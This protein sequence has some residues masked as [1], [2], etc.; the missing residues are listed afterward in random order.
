MYIYNTTTPWRASFWNEMWLELYYV[1]RIQQ[2]LILSCNEGI[3]Y[4]HQTKTRKTIHILR[5]IRYRVPFS[6]RKNSNLFM[7]PNLEILPC[8]ELRI[9]HHSPLQE[10]MPYLTLISNWY[11]GIINSKITKFACDWKLLIL[12]EDKGQETY[13]TNIYGARI[14]LL[15]FILGS[16]GTSWIF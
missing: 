5:R 7:S 8:N 3:R 14:D 11:K 13:I 6:S 4:R 15:L 2:S 9:S 12:E 16:R 1:E 10:F